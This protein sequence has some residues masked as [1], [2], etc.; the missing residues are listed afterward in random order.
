MIN[1]KPGHA[2][3]NGR[4][5]ASVHNCVLYMHL[6]ARTDVLDARK[7]RNDSS[8]YWVSVNESSNVVLDLNNLNAVSSATGLDISI[9]RKVIVCIK[10]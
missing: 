3:H 1:V 5:T 4:T 6:I 8:V 7:K 2:I 9:V 10:R